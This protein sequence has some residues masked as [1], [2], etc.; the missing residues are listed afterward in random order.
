MCVYMRVCD[1]CGC[2]VA[3]RS[4]CVSVTVIQQD[5]RCCRH[6]LGST[7]QSWSECAVLLSQ[8]LSQS[9]AGW[10]LS[11]PLALWTVVLRVS[12]FGTDGFPRPRLQLSLKRWGKETLCWSLEA[13][14]TSRGRWAF[15]STLF[16]MSL[17]LHLGV[18]R[19]F[20]LLLRA[21]QSVWRLCDSWIS[22]LPGQLLLWRCSGKWLRCVFVFLVEVMPRHSITMHHWRAPLAPQT[23][24]L[25]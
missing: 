18:R 22:C 4:S 8:G 20:M 16:W 7:R 19:C 24:E 1:L 14:W 12:S 5:S 6:L 9:A 2:C 3:W 17:Q 15:L 21:C 11:P 25:M 13:T 10:R 23:T